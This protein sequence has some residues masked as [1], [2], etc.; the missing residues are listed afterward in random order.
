MT[1]KVS[2]FLSTDIWRLRLQDYP[3]AT[4]FFLRH[5]R[6]AVL[7]VRGFIEDKCP[8]RASSL[9]FFSLLS[10]GP[11]IALAFGLAKGF[12]MEEYL[13]TQVIKKIPAQEELLQDIT[14]YAKA[15]LDETKGAVIAGFG[16]VLL[17]WAVLKALLHIETSVNDIWKIKRSRSWKRRL[18]NYLAFLI[19]APLL[20]VIYTSVPAFLSSQILL[21]AEKLVILDKISPV[22]IGLLNWTPYVVICGIFTFIYL[23]IPNTRVNFLSGMLGGIIAGTV[24]IAVQW[25]YISFQV[26]VTRLNPIY[27]SLAALP[28]ML[29]WLNLGWN[30]F[31]IGAEYSYAHQH[32]DSYEYDQDFS[33]ISPHFRRLLALQ[34]LRLLALRFSR[35]EPPLAA[36]KISHE[37]EIPIRQVSAIL[38]DLVSCGLVSDIH[39]QEFNDHLFQPGSD[40]RLWTL[41][42]TIA[43]MEKNGVN[44]IPVGN[45]EEMRRLE[46]AMEKMGDAMKSSSGNRLITEL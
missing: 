12:G 20:M 11:L 5:L 37:L 43:A 9:T 35:S 30:I 15:L 10:V 25:L 46:G 26:G 41:S 16:I 28:L 22:L 6:I 3:P 24:F 38:S 45:S 13:E 17:I 39:R 44:Q 27:G 29:I 4:S 34:I 32:V 14:L 1:T 2:Q 21:V 23:I 33:N 42:Y 31:L 19:I 8:I 18:I 36:S 7:T 40:I